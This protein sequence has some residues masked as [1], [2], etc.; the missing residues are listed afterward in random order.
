MHA[1]IQG[2]SPSGRGSAVHRKSVNLS[3]GVRVKWTFRVQN[4]NT[5][6]SR[7]HHWLDRYYSVATRYLQAYLGWQRALDTH[8]SPIRKP[9]CAR[10]SAFFTFNVVVASFSGRGNNAHRRHGWIK[11][12]L[13][14]AQ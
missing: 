3:T 9:C 13:A 4:V 1:R 11:P 2:A 6:L 14:L 12:A 8:R 10:P 7:L 5:C